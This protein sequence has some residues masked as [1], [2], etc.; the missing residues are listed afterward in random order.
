MEMYIKNLLKIAKYK[1][2]PLFGNKQQNEKN[3]D[4]DISGR[5]SCILIVNGCHNSVGWWSISAH[6]AHSHY[7]AFD[8]HDVKA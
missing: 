7:H 2:V 4:S 3:A 5:Y 6:R 8:T 1:S